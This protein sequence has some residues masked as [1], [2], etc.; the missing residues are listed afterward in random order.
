MPIS[1]TNSKYID[2]NTVQMM[3]HKDYINIM[4]I[5]NDLSNFVCLIF[6]NPQDSVRTLKR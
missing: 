4:D 3:A 2:A 1:L 5:I 6:G